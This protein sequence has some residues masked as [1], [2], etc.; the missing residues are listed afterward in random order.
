MDGIEISI[1]PFHEWIGLC[2]SAAFFKR[3]FVGASRRMILDFI[4][5][6]VKN[7]DTASIGFPTGFARSETLVGVGDTLVVLFAIFV[8]NRVRRRIPA[9]PEVFLELL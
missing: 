4:G 6:A 7:I 9:Q 8:F 1:G 5:L 3:P 2:R